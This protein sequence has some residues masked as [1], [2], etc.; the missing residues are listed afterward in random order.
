MPSAETLQKLARV[1]VMAGVLTAAPVFSLGAQ[2][3]PSESSRRSVVAVRLEQRETVV[4]DGVLDEAVWMRAVPATDFVQQDPVNGAP[5]TERT[6]VRFAVSRE[7]LYMGVTCFDS[8]PDRM[9]GN[10]MSATNSSGPTTAS[11]G[12]SIRFSTGRAAISSK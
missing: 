11:C 7:A 4:L 3:T 6:E 10:T 8:E 5:P 1:A 12:C 2:D 9:L